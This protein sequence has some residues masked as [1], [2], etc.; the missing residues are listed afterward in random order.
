MLFEVDSTS[1]TTF[2]LVRRFFFQGVKVPWTD[3]YLMDSFLGSF[4][5]I[6]LR[7]GV[8]LMVRVGLP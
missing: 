2:I 3:A 5:V 1:A 8:V 6:K 4:K 7:S